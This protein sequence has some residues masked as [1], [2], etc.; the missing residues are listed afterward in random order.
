M[1][2]VEQF[3]H[4]INL[5]DQTRYKRWTQYRNDINTFLESFL[6]YR[7]DHLKNLLVIGAGHCDDIDLHFL[8]NHFD[9]VVLSDIDIKGMQSGIL[10]QGY[11]M[12]DFSIVQTDFTGF[13]ESGFFDHLID[14]LF[15]IKSE[16]E[17]SDYLTSKFTSMI[18]YKFMDPVD[19]KYD[20]IIVLPIYTQLI[21]NQILNATSVLR[22]I[23]Y[24][25]D[26]I[27]FI[28]DF[29]LQQMIPIIDNFN[30]NINRLLNPNGLLFILSDIFQSRIN[31]PF[32]TRV[33]QG[34]HSRNIMDQLHQEYLTNHGYGLGDYG[35]YSITSTFNLIDYKWLIWPFELELDLVIKIAY[36]T[37]K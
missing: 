19:T 8:K 2:L 24:P 29:S 15:L 21:Y 1:K 9:K 12:Y 27:Q 26:L 3:N 4:D 7:K 13:E 22:A 34:I 35:L 10:A 23:D 11:K 25:E 18:D 5:S 36:L 32:H 17:I 30:K 6:A 28:N 33:T 31:E 16:Q 37:H 20:A 14:D